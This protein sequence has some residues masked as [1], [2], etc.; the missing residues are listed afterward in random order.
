M[1]PAVLE[2]NRHEPSTLRQYRTL[3]AVSQVIAT[4]RDLQP[5]LH[6][7]AGQVGQVIQLDALSLVLHEAATNTM[8]LHA[9]ETR[10]SVAS[11]SAFVLAPE[12][13]PAGLVW[14]TQRPLITSRMAEMSRWPRLLELVQRYGV[15]S[16]CWLPLTTARQR[17]GAMVFTSKEPAA[18]DGA[19]VDF[20]QQVANQVA[21]AVENA[22]SFGELA[23]IKDQ[24]LGEKAYLEEE[25]RTR[26]VGQ[27]VAVSA[28]LR[29]VLKRV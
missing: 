6:D 23:A 11:A 13:D 15:Q 10:E 8:R 29:Q 9:L 7:L 21:L 24:L 25:V 17:L 3:L 2:R 12:D 1:G 5:L 26:D 16:N 28:P 4:H 22:V 19:D 18:Y 20:L 14:Q 27:M